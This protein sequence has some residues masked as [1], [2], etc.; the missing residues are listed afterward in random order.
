MEFW[1]IFASN[2]INHYEFIN[3]IN[4][5][6]MLLKNT[7]EEGKTF[8]DYLQRGVRTFKVQK[9]SD[10]DF[11]KSLTKTANALSNFENDGNTVKSHKACSNFIS[12]INDVFGGISTPTIKEMSVERIKSYTPEIKHIVKDMKTSRAFNRVCE[13]YGIDKAPEYNKLFAKYADMVSELKRQLD[14]IISLNPYDYL[15]M[16]FGVNWQSCHDIRR[17]GMLPGGY[18]G[19]TMS[20]M[21]DASSIITYVISRNGDPTEAKIYRN[22]FHFGGNKLVQGRIYPQGNDGI[23]DLYTTFRGFMQTELASLL[24]VENSWGHINNG[25]TRT[26]TTLGAHYRDYNYNVSCNMTYPTNNR[27]R[28]G[29]LTIGHEGIC[30]HCGRPYT[31]SNRLAHDEC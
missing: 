11:H 10:E 24:G 25:W 23:T 20:Y 4:P 27:L 21:L 7:D 19:G 8:T 17:R 2:N 29:D 30:T 15:T 12:T 6:S 9:L 5:S 31:Y 14:F 28:L 22:M 16:S 13:H 26:I 1:L 3:S 18:C